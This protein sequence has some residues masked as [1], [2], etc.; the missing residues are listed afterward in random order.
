MELY[1][2]HVFRSIDGYYSTIQDTVA[3]ALFKKY[4]KD[5]F[6]NTNCYYTAPG[7]LPDIQQLEF[8]IFFNLYSFS[9][10]ANKT[11]SENE[12]PLCLTG[13]AKAH[14]RFNEPVPNSASPQSLFIMS[15]YPS[16][17]EMNCQY[18]FNTSYRMSA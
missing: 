8:E 9:L 13:N 3:S 7:N 18:L 1:N 2:V 11:Y 16:V 4:Y 12:L 10:T 14:L 5:L 15:I 6:L 17:L